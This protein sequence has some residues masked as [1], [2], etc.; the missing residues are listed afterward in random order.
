MK[1]VIISLKAH[2]SS[3]NREK[4]PEKKVSEVETQKQ[5]PSKKGFDDYISSLNN[6]DDDMVNNREDLSNH[7]ED[8]METSSSFPLPGFEQNGLNGIEENN[9]EHRSHISNNVSNNGYGEQGRCNLKK[10]K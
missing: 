8:M 3:R 2:H 1:S 9:F 10:I 4:K 7:Q 5:Q 6:N